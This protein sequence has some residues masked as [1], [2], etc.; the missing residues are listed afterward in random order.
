MDQET[1][2]QKMSMLMAPCACGSGKMAGFCCKVGETKMIEN[3]MCVCGS[4]K[5]IKDCCMKN[6]ETHQGI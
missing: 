6:P 2:K 5:M 1:L 4:G 3:E